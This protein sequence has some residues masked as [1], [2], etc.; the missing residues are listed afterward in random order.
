[1]I[2]LAC[3]ERRELRKLYGYI[4]IYMEMFQSEDLSRIFVHSVS[5]F[6]MMFYQ[7]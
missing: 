5:G 2:F 6:S 3:G 4:Y 1:M 7:N